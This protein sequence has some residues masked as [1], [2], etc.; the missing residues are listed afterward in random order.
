MSGVLEGT[1]AKRAFWREPDRETFWK[2]TREKESSRGPGRLNKARCLELY[3]G[4]P[5]GSG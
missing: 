4:C 2:G 5:T 3:Y 1:I